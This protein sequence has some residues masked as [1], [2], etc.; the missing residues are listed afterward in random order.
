[1]ERRNI[2]EAEIRVRQEE[3]QVIE[4]MLQFINEY[5]MKHPS[6][7]SSNETTLQQSKNLAVEGKN[8]LF[9]IVK[10]FSICSI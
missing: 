3:I 7:V 5:P 4:D 10:K 2:K 1:M 8:A 9:F 6:S